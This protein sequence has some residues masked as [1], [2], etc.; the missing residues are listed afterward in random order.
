MDF[1]RAFDRVAGLLEAR[2][3]S[4]AVVG[5]LGLHAYGITRAT[6]DLDVVTESAAQDALVAFLEG[7][8]YETLHRSAFY[9]NHLHPEP[10]SGRF[11]FIYVDPETARRLFPTCR[12]LLQLGTRRALVPRPE[13][14]VA[15]KVQAIRNDPARALQDLA[16]VLALLR[17]PGV[18]VDEA[19]GYFER[20]GLRGEWD[21]V[22][23]R[24]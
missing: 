4:L 3:A 13:H 24:L 17:L 8:G 2:G 22:R 23:R 6:Q 11:D 14:L 7:E 1:A 15:M 21:E 12:P 20:A 16:D 18:D 19:H 9:S 5:G 10:S